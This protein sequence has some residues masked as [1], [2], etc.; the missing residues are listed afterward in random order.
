[1]FAFDIRY[2]LFP[3]AFRGVFACQVEEDDILAYEIFLDRFGRSH[4]GFARAAPGRPEIDKHDFAPVRRGDGVEQLLGRDVG[5]V[6]AVDGV[7]GFLFVFFDCLLELV[8]HVK[9]GGT[10]LGY[11]LF[12]QL[13]L[14][15]IQWFKLFD[16]GG[17]AASGEHLE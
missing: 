2:H 3:S 13:Q 16:R 17:K 1:M 4:R 9:Q 7:A 14:F 11:R 10:D 5:N 8:V 12:G 15:F 6:H